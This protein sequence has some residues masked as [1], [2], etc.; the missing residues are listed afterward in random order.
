MRSK[1]FLMVCVTLFAVL[2]GS[3]AWGAPVNFKFAHSGSLE[4][5][6]QIGA[7]HFKKLVEEKS[8][9]EMTV[10]IFPQAQLGGER[11][12]AEGVRMGTIEV[13]SLAASNLATFVP[14]LQVFGVP[15]LYTT[16]EQVYSVLDGEVGQELA[17]IILGKG[18]RN[19]GFWEVGFRNITNNI[20]PVKVPEDMKGL[21]IRVQESKIW[22]EFMRSL[23]AIATPIP[24]GELYTALQQKVTDG[25]ENP[26]ATI[27]SMKFYE[28][29]KYVT[30]TGHTYEPAVVIANPKWFNGLSEDQQRIILEA[31]AETTTYQRAKLA[32]L[33][34]E[35]LDAI[36][37][38]GVEI[39]ENPD[40]EAFM[41]ATKDLYKVLSDVVPES[42]VQKIRDEVAKVQ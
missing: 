27:Y 39:E 23:G 28:V 2:W 31:T 1:R 11:D 4:H 40:K 37:E 22:I 29:Q 38:A 25:E 32:E 12:L 17:E 19:L 16:L 8:G 20:R 14:E 33:E 6:Y 15:F 42:L 21:K 9:G 34:K 30:M 10:T 5:Q 41:E 3:V 13:V 18:F 35:R 36:R 24:F 26:I 7:E